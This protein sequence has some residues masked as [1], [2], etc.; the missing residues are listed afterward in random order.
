MKKFLLDFGSFVSSFH[1]S[2]LVAI[3]DALLSK[4]DIARMAPFSRKIVPDVEAVTGSAFLDSMFPQGMVML[5]TRIEPRLVPTQRV[6]NN[7]N[8]AKK[9]HHNIIDVIALNL[10]SKVE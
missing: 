2:K 3:T 10:I 5:T 8:S 1:R 4:N 9:N 7:E 6:G